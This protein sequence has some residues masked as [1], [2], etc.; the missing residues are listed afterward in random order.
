MAS[1]SRPTRILSAL[2]LSSL[3]VSG[4][5]AS[6]AE[7]VTAPGVPEVIYGTDDRLESYE[8]TDFGLAGLFRSEVALI[9]SYDLIPYPGGWVIDTSYTFSDYMSPL[10][11]DEPYAD[12]PVPGFC[13]G[14]PV[15]PDLITTA[16]HCVT[17]QDDCGNTAFVFGFRMLSPVTVVQDLPVDDVYFCDAIVARAQTA[18]DDW[19]ILRTDRPILGH[20]PLR[21]RRSGAVESDPLV[22]GLAVIGYPVGMPAK[23]AGGAAV[24]SAAHPDYF[25]ANL[26]VYI[27]SSGS[28]VLSLDPGGRPYR[29]EGIL[30]RGNADFA[31]TGSCWTSQICPDDTGCGGTWEESTRAT[32]FEIQVPSVPLPGPVPDGA[33]VPGLPLTVQ[34]VQ[35]GLVRLQWG[36]AC[37]GELADYAVY[38]GTLGDFGSHLPVACSTDHQ[39]GALVDDPPGEGSY[40]LVVA[41]HAHVEGSY[42][43]RS[44][45][46]ERPPS[47]AACLH[48]ELGGCGAAVADGM[49]RSRDRDSDDPD[50]LDLDGDGVV[51]LEDNCPLVS[52]PDQSDADGDSRGDACDN[53]PDDPSPSQADHDGDG[54]GDACDPAPDERFLEL[55]PV[56]PPAPPGS[57]LPFRIRLVNDTQPAVTGKILFG[58]RRVTVGQPTV[59]PDQV[60]FPRT[61]FPLAVA[62]R[63]ERTW[64]CWIQTVG[65]PGI[66][67]GRSVWFDA[68]FLS[69]RLAAPLRASLS[70]RL[71]GSD[72]PI[73][74]DPAELP[75]GGGAAQIRAWILEPDGSPVPGAEVRFE[76]DRG[77]LASGGVPVQT[78]ATGLA[79]DELT[80]MEPATVTVRHADRIG[81]IGVSVGALAGS[82][83]LFATTGTTGPAPLSLSFLLRVADT[84]GQAVEG[85]PFDPRVDGDGVVEVLDP[86]TDSSGIGRFDVVG[87]TQDGTRISVAAGGR[88]SNPI[89]ITITGSP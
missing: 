56:W 43:L 63:S 46:A 85:L 86:V 38:R 61:P 67:G 10:C 37:P 25:E 19:A 83:S 31:W 58:T 3:A 16:G 88:V 78:D 44:D 65:W 22:D 50:P 42:G 24:R 32:N 5:G 30:V 54:L 55:V 2:F 11:P 57:R 39:T 79:R 7:D 48:Q 47:A 52:N 59:R 12:Q 82:L 27:A 9:P 60:C 35:E 8:V 80:T 18:T 29:V 73:Q 36:P 69:P 6:P 41:H 77:E 20:E 33:A 71:L 68:W 4:S 28:A 70:V 84:T 64:D 45:G 17:D 49:G 72:L 40:Y 21:L 53:C 14:F 75:S 62:S 74:A 81:S 23:L 87:V 15:G 76:T 1:P 34:L 66:H 51:D 26:D 13:S 89:T